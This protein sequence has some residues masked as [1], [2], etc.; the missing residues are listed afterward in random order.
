MTKAILSNIDDEVSEVREQSN[1]RDTV[2]QTA[3]QTSYSEGYCDGISALVD[4][5][6]NL[7]LED[8]SDGSE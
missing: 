8:D 5:I 2:D 4:S 1:V 3:M 7:N 6:D